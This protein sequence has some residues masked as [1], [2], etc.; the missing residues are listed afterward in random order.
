MFDKYSLTNIENNLLD[1]ERENELPSWMVP[2]CYKK[3]QR[4]PNR[5][6]GLIK[7][8]IDH[9]YYDIYSMP[10]ILHKLLMN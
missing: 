6:V 5:Y 10:L 7:E 1:L 3:Y 2:E 8:C 9:N 4:N